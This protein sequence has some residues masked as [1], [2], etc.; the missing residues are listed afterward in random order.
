MN[1][2]HVD[3]QG[4]VWVGTK[5][6]L[7][8][9]DEQRQSFTRYRQENG[10]G[11]DFIQG[12]S[13]D[14]SQL[15]ISTNRGLSKLHFQTQ[16]IRNYD[17]GDGL[18]PGA[19]NRMAVFR[20]KFGKFYFG[21]INGLIS[22][23][24]EQV[25]DNSYIPPVYL[26]KVKIFDQPTSFASDTLNLKYNQSTLTFEFAALNYTLPEKNQYAYRLDGFDD[27]WQ[28]SGNKREA[29]YTNLNPGEYTFRVKA[30]NNDGVW[31]EQ[32]TALRIVITPPF[33]LTW[34]FKALAGS[35]F[36]ATPLILI[37]LRIRSLKLQKT[38]LEKVVQER[39][40]EV[41][42]QKEE[43]LTQS[44]HLLTQSEHLQLLVEELNEQRT[45][46][47]KAREEAEKANKA[48]SVFLATMSHEIRT[49]MNGVL[50]MAYLMKE[51]ELSADQTEY[52]DTIVQCG[53]SLLG[54]I[55]D[56]LDFSKIESGNLELEPSEVNL[57]NSIESVLELFAGKAAETGLD[58][59]CQLEPQV[60]THIL[61][62]GLRLR[63]ILINLVG[64]AV[65]F[66]HKGEVFVQVVVNQLLDN[67]QVE[68]L[69][70]VRDTGIGISPEKQARLF[71]SFSQGDSSMTRRYG[72]TG[73]GLVIS[74]RLVKLMGGA[75]RVESQEG[76]GTS[77]S[78]TVRC[79][80]VTVP[81]PWSSS[82]HVTD[83]VEKRILIVD[84][85]ATNLT[86]L[87]A[88]L[89]LWGQ[90]PT[91]ASSGS[92]AMMILEKSEPFHLV[93]TDMQMLGMSGKELARKIR[94]KETALPIILLSSVKDDLR[95]N[96]DGLFA[97]VLTKPIR[98]H[99]LREL[100]LRQLGQTSVP[101]TPGNR[102]APQQQLVKS[103]AQDHPLTILVAEDYLAN[104]KLILNVLQR[105]GYNPVIVP[106]GVE[107]VEALQKEVYDLILMDVQMPEMNGLEATRL[108]RSQPGLQPVIVAMTANAM[109]EDY[110]EC[111]QAGMD[112]YLSKPI[113]MEALKKTL[114]QVADRRQQVMNS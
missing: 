29:V 112:D 20:N 13:S 26:T 47:Q 15:W 25:R 114:A 34:W 9:F 46:E 73:L 48:K 104:Q 100:V 97:A 23:T 22:F 111:I 71:K 7:N 3:L 43:L 50:G 6:G 68:L 98:Q 52:V 4:R 51:T 62:D 88:Q 59:V 96:E 93:M 12:I 101:Q 10:L 38:K 74:E 106:N 65:K 19:F 83:P 54:V 69:F 30:S 63:Q 42:Y 79:P 102:P 32:G 99:H 21:G 113:F 40:A 39:T 89:E 11:N 27:Q 57:L 36:L 8:L 78:F 110:E 70:T 90:S 66:T 75:I 92:E 80:M 55:N 76:K 61:I 2:L 16:K 72:G 17:E 5:Q 82:P 14:S 53:E 56:I 107:V 45:Q 35:L 91:V 84:D 67:Q 31:N 81:K 44:E 85:N 18:L 108:I 94:E 103:F 37:R 109:K 86:V 105:L 24:P 60:P 33:W 77:F 95:K 87:K 49:P 1:S 64:N 28:F 58:L 41:Q